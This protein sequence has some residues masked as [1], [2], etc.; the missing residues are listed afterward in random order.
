MQNAVE[1]DLA[2][3]AWVSS[4]EIDR[5]NTVLAGLKEQERKLLNKHYADEISDEL[6][7][8]EQAR[9]KRERADTEVIV[10]R[11]TVSHD[12]LLEM[13]ALALRLASFDLQDLYRRST[14]QIRRLMN[15]AIFEAIWV[16]HDEVERSRLTSPLRETHELAG[17]V[18][19]DSG[20]DRHRRP[21]KPQ[22]PRPGV[23]GFGRWLD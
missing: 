17:A 14:P 1:A 20:R 13:L 15:Q 19:P 8:D 16:S 4:E 3:L 12:D 21:R 5:C 9:I 23:G 10:A 11:L 22:S 6:F 2:N 18:G 7:S